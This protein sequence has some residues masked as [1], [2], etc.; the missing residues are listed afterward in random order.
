EETL[1]RNML[2]ARMGGSKRKGGDEQVEKKKSGKKKDGGSGSTIFHDSDRVKEGKEVN[3]GSGAKGISHKEISNISGIIDFKKGYTLFDKEAHLW[4]P[5]EFARDLASDKIGE[6]SAKGRLDVLA[7]RGRLF[8][9][10]DLNFKK[11]LLELGLGAQGAFELI[12][13]HIELKHDAPNVLL[14]GVD[15]A[16]HTV[17]NG[18]AY[19]GAVAE[20][21]AIL[22]L[23]WDN[24]FEKS[25][26]QLG[27]QAFAGA[28]A[29]ISGSMSL[30]KLMGVRA[31]ADAYAGVGAK[32][33]LNV[34]F[35]DGELNVDTGL[36]AAVLAGA[37]YDVGFSV[38]FPEIAKLG[39][40]LG[41]QFMASPITFP[42]DVLQDVGHVLGTN[43]GSG[44]Y[45]LDAAFHLTGKSD[46]PS[47]Y[48]TREEQ[49]ITERLDEKKNQRPAQPVA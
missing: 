14:G 24:F 18:D 11:S 6:A 37:G 30:G 16:L 8:G 32:A 21:G 7:V 1:E 25:F 41:D 31:K 2:K 33:L 4:R 44:L 9:L 5:I 20:G 23:S 15:A 49:D 28:A 46:V 38:N 42:R 36:G 35:K 3:Y 48:S 39:G 40:G 12:G 10:A 19:V 45:L 43:F 34:G 26:L 27:G 47:D 22:N 17:I 29:S 13:G